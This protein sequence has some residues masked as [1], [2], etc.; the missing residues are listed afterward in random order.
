MEIPN[1]YLNYKSDQ[2]NETTEVYFK[3]ENWQ[4]WDIETAKKQTIELSRQGKIGA[5]DFVFA[6][7]AD[8]QFLFYKD[9]TKTTTKI[10]HLDEENDIVYFAFSLTEFTNYEQTQNLIEEL[11]EIESLDFKNQD[12]SSIENCIGSLFNYAFELNTSEYDDDYSD[13]RNGR[14]LELFLIAANEGHPEAAHEL[15]S[16]YYFQEEVDVDKVIEWREKAIEYGSKEDIYELADFIIDEK[17]EA[18]DRAITLLESLFEEQWYKERALLKLSRIYMRGTGGKLDYKKGLEYVKACAAL[19]NS[20]AISDLAYYYY[21]GMGV[22]KD[23][24]KAL[25]LLVKA[26]AKVIEQSGSGMWGDFIKK[27]EKELKD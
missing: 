16:H 24:K 22:E 27:L 25:E 2:L 17:I 3:I 9:A 14:A 6:M 10:Y 23:I 11:E 1:D 5:N 21:Q 8:Q 7:N 26:E 15:A 12:L 19:D 20:N 13:E 18:I 4:I